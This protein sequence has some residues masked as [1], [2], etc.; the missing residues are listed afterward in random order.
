MAIPIDDIDQLRNG[1]IHVNGTS[2]TTA[3]SGLVFCSIKA[4]GS[5]DATF[6]SLAGGVN[7]AGMILKNGVE[8]IGLFPSFQLTSGAVWARYARVSV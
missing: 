5:G 6:T 2:L 3:P 1:G 7:T 8:I 4:V